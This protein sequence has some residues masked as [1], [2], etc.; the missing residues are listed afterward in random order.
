MLCKPSINSAGSSDSTPSQ[1]LPLPSG[2]VDYDDL[3]VMR[4]KQELPL[5]SGVIDFDDLPV[6]R[7]KQELPPPS[8][9]IDFDDLP[10]MRKKPRKKTKDAAA[11]EA[12]ADGQPGGN[13]PHC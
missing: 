10:V 13:T 9:V 11:L 3:P 8:G 4:K 6:M 2:V 7:K 12:P 5:P 1:E